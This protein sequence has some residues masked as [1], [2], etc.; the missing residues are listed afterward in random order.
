M[1]RWPAILAIVFAGIAAAAQ[2][3][4]VPAA[5]TT[6]AAE[7]G[8]SLA[9]AA[10]LVS[11]AAL[12]AGLGGLAIGLAAARIGARR[13]LLAGLSL[14]ALAAAVAPLAPS[15][16]PL[17]AIRIA[18]GAGFL[19]IVV[20]APSLVAA[21]AAPADRPSAMGLWGG[22]MPGGIALGLFTAPVVEAAGWR[23]AWL[24]CAA[25]LLAGLVLCW[26]L[27]PRLPP[28]A[29]GPRPRL[30]VQLRALMA[31]RRPLRVAAAFAA[32]S[33]VYF[34]IAA[35]LPAY[36]E[37]LG[38]GTGAAGG[39]AALAAI[40]NLAGNLSAAALMRRGVAPERLAT[41][42]AA[43]MALLA[44]AVFALPLPSSAMG[45]ALLACGVGG[46]VPAS[47]FALVPASVPRPELVA[48]AMGLT[49]Q[50]NNLVQL[51][52]PPL[53]GVLAGLGWALLALPL[54]AAG[55]LAAWV[56]VILARGGLPSAPPA[57]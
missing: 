38:V 47:L 57:T 16:P 50:G 39:A 11:L 24:L 40:A 53:L 10:L 54:L 20:S 44:A 56:G 21:L 23:P 33:C 9:A 43:A 51:L 14:A 34:G 2:I 15:A 45:L 32:Y 17:F 48:P 55:L 27:I 5:M 29:S 31:A 46:L 30:A 25:L 3:G 13:G 36:L 37:S 35:F 12:F 26:R 18:E 42:G 41:A 22:F 28:V 6:I 52:A 4:K 8:L 7:F 19:L 49:I 1:T